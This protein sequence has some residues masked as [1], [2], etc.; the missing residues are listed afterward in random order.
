V[1]AEIEQARLR[2]Q[3]AARHVSGRGGDQDLTAIGYPEEAGTAVHA[4]AEIVV[5][6]RLGR[7]GVHRHAH[8]DAAD[9]REVFAAERLLGGKGRGD[10]LGG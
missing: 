8:L 2:R 5:I 3:P 9:L 1:L 7:T 4:L 6:A 10:R